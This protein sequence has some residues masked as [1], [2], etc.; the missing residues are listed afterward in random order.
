MHE[1]KLLDHFKRTPE[2][3]ISIKTERIKFV[4]GARQMLE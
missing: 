4:G 3:A 1:K 2:A